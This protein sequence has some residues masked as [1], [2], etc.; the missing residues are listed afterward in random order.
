MLSISASHRPHGRAIPGYKDARGVYL[1]VYLHSVERVRVTI[2]LKEVFYQNHDN[3]VQALW[4][5]VK[6][7][8]GDEQ[9][10]RANFSDRLGRIFGLGSSTCFTADVVKERLLLVPTSLAGCNTLTLFAK[11]GAI[12]Y[13]SALRDRIFREVGV[14]DD[15]GN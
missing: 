10:I 7:L 3:D 11:W 9:P 6:V 2:R 1:C 4:V 5:V 15:I 12:C 14:E 8:F 13:H